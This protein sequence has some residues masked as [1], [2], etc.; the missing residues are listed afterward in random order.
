MVYSLNRRADASVQPLRGLGRAIFHQPPQL[1]DVSDFL[2]GRNDA[3]LLHL[4]KGPA[5]MHR[6]LRPGSV[7]E[8]WY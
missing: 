7:E 6:R 5:G 8:S 3:K 2:A 4:G 1:L